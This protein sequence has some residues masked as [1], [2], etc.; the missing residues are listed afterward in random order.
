MKALGVPDDAYDGVVTSGD[1]TRDLIAER[2]GVRIL[3]I[4]PER[5]LPF[6]DG[7]DVALASEA[8]AELISCTGLCRRHRRDPGGLRALLQRLRRRAA[9]R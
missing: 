3:H 2:P 6:Y 5:D 4:G 7:L 1:V 8:D 9:F